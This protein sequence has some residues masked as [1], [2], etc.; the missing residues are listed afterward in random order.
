MSKHTVLA[1]E[2]GSILSVASFYLRMLHYVC[3][4]GVDI[5]IIYPCVAFYRASLVVGRWNDLDTINDF[6]EEIHPTSFLLCYK[7]EIIIIHN[8]CIIHT[9][10][11]DTRQP[12]PIPATILGQ[13]NTTLFSFRRSA[14]VWRIL[15]SR[16]ASKDFSINR[17]L[18]SLRSH[19][20][21]VFLFNRFDGWQFK[22]YSTPLTLELDQTAS[23]ILVY[24]TGSNH[25]YRSTNEYNIIHQFDSM[26]EI[27]GIAIRLSI[28]HVKYKI[29]NIWHCFW[30]S[31]D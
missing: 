15:L 5:C 31:L 18:P 27:V 13:L 9:T 21:D 7:Y 2:S 6:F 26:G 12:A 24:M 10:R 11:I 23:A 28:H 22:D 8:I 3:D 16:T 29:Q 14:R 4:G 30:I 25:Q 17:S 20:I 1:I 19:P